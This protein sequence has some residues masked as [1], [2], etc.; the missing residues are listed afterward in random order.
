M[1][2]QNISKRDIQT[3]NHKFP[4][5][6]CMLIQIL[7]PQEDFP[8]PKYNFKEI[9]Q[10]EF[11]DVEETGYTNLGDGEMTDVSELCIS[12]NQA[13]KLAE[14]LIHAR[15]N[16]MNVV[17]HCHA[18]IFRSGA[19]AEV[20]IILGFEDTHAFRCPNR[21]VK[22][23]IL[24]ALNLKYDPGEPMTINGVLSKDSKTAIT[25]SGHRKNLT[26]KKY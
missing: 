14:L 20:G 22:H 23:K 3:G 6:N 2:I 11:L 13:K 8:E 9:H 5:D 17:V 26:N 19:V 15:N 7:D 18:G 24:K 10:F 1:W 21:L 12:D 4:G 25:I 16:N